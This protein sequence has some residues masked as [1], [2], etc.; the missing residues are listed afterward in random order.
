MPSLGQQ[1]T[2][3][4]GAALAATALGIPRRDIPRLVKA[5]E[6]HPAVKLEGRTGAYLFEASEVERVR[7]AR[8][9]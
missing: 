5:D 2:K 1:E 8:A 7:L 9:S 6:L 3:L 4:I